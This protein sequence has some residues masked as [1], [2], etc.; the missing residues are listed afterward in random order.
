VILKKSLS[1]FRKDVYCNK[2]K[3]IE[4]LY[5]YGL[6]WGDDRYAGLEN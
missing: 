6:G 3:G 5:S 4:A 1:F 2:G